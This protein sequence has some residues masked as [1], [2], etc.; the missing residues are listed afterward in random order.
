MS[1][2]AVA[3]LTA[4]RAFGLQKCPVDLDLAGVAD[5]VMTYCCCVSAHCPASLIEDIR[6]ATLINAMVIYYF[7]AVFERPD[8]HA[9]R[10][11]DHVPNTIANG[12][13]VGVVKVMIAIFPDRILIVCVHSDSPCVVFS[14][15]LIT[16]YSNQQISQYKNQ[17]LAKLPDE[18]SYEDAA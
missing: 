10:P 17:R 14:L 3:E 2:E 8:E 5:A 11:V 6:K 4:G 18:R 16:V 15:T 7:F 12:V 13:A 9:D 1:D